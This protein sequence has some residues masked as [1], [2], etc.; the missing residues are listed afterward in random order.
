MFQFKRAKLAC[1]AAMFLVVGCR[2]K[3]D[4][5]V[6]N[7]KTAINDYYRGRQECV[8]A[9]PMKFPAQADASKDEQTKGLMR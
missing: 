1:A 8:W 4:A 6:A 7:F 3:N 2:G 9:G 5:D